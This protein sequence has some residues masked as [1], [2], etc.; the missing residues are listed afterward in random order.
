MLT[1]SRSQD[2]EIFKHMMTF[3]RLAEQMHNGGRKLL[4]LFIRRFI[5]L[6]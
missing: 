4:F 6:Y 1:Q 2:W 3:E 5:L